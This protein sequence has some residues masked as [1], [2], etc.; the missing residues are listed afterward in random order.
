MLEAI[1]EIRNPP[2]IKLFIYI[3][4][5]ESVVRGPGESADRAVARRQGCS[6]TGSGIIEKQTGTEE[7]RTWE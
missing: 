5:I 7:F 6:G 2:F 3:K 4:D 1:R